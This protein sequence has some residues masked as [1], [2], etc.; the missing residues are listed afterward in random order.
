M[1]ASREQNSSQGNGND[2]NNK[3]SLERNQNGNSK[4]SKRD[5]DDDTVQ[6]QNQGLQ[7]TKTE[8]NQDSGS[9]GTSTPEPSPA[10]GESGL[11]LQLSGESDDEV[12]IHCPCR[13]MEA[14]GSSECFNVTDKETM[15]CKPRPC[16]ASYECDS[17]VTDMICMLRKASKKTLGDVLKPGYCMEKVID[18]SFY[19]FYDAGA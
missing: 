13:Q 18:E 12:P 16:G 11:G 6:G 17:S 9:G 1:T 5:E 4:N 10:E 19:V 3:A 15:R 8:N 7:K 2:S 14:S